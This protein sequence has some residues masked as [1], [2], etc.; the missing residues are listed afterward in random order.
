MVSVTGLPFVN[1]D[2]IAADRFG[3]EAMIRSHEAAEIAE[4]TRSRL[5]DMGQSFIA[6]TVAS[7][8]SKVALVR[9]AKD[10]GYV[11]TIHV[12]MIPEALA[13]PRVAA[14]VAAGGHDV[15]PDRVIARYRRLWPLV[16]K[17]IG[18]ADEAGIYDNS[19]DTRPLQRVGRFRQGDPVSPPNWPDWTPQPLRDLTT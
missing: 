15:P 11:V 19:R 17:M 2:L 8:P 14:R 6:E 1:A 3:A 16:A 7:H 10:A 9:H 12:V 4:A 5:I 13:V 18:M